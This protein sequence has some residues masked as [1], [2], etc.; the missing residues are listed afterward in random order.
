MEFRT[1]D[2]F[3]K[4]LVFNGFKVRRLAA[5]V[6]E[7]CHQSPEFNYLPPFEKLVGGSEKD[8]QSR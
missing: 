5:R 3:G 8:D 6:R 1:R 4:V 7:G 2:F